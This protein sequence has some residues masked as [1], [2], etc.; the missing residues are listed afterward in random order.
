VGGTTPPVNHSPP[1]DRSQPSPLAAPAFKI[2]PTLPRTA[3][4]LLD[5][6]LGIMAVAYQ[7]ISDAIQCRG[8]LV[9]QDDKVVP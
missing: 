5:N 6:V 9:D 7:P 4:C 3:Q 8:V 1:Q 2:C